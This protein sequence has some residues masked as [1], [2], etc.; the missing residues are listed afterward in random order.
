[1]NFTEDSQKG[2]SYPQQEKV[3][4]VEPHINIA[5]Q[6][7]KEIILNYDPIQ[8]NE[9]CRIIRQNVSEQRALRIEGAEKDL[10]YLKQSLENL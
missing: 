6:I 7:A 4:A 9:M 5:Q 8:Q 10:A 3:A 2:G 1:M